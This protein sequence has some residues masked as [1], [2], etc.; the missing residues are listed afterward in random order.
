MT[1]VIDDFVKKFH[2]DMHESSFGKIFCE[3]LSERR[4]MGALRDANIFTL[5]KGACGDSMLLYFKLENGIVQDASFQTDGCAPSVVCGSY[6]AELCI[7][8]SPEA[9][10]DI[11]A[12]TIIDQFGALPEKVRH[13]AEL[14]AGTVH[15]AADKCMRELIAT[16]RLAA[17]PA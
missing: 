7:G 14:A 12:E 4:Y 8:K 15:A 1:D 17:D 13:C 9:L 3:R 11:S 5:K 6:A 2:A 10:F 16:Q